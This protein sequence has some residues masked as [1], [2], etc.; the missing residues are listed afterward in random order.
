MLMLVSNSIQIDQNSPKY[1]KKTKLFGYHRHQKTKLFGNHRH[2][3][4]VFISP[5]RCLIFVMSLKVLKRFIS[6]LASNRK[7]L[8]RG[9]Q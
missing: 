2:Q 8:F 4:V 9:R 7:V 5:N 6:K 3:N 1:E